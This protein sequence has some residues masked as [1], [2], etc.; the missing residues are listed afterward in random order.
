[1]CWVSSGPKMLAPWGSP[2][3]LYGDRELQDS[4]RAEGMK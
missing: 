1:M 3:G 2:V 4:G